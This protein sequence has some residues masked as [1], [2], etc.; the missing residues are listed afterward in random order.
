M[1]YV[2]KQYVK[3]FLNTAKSLKKK[4]IKITEKLPL[5][6]DPIFYQVSQMVIQAFSIQAHAKYGDY[7][8]K[9]YSNDKALAKIGNFTAKKSAQ[10]LC[11]IG[12]PLEKV[13]VTSGLD[14]I[15]GQ[16]SD[17]VG[18]NPKLLAK[19]KLDKFTGQLELFPQK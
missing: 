7:S 16:L 12:Y 3:V 4:G 1:D 9:T 6:V 2:G 8:P 13:W 14:E 15:F 11:K 5:D 17:A 10:F 18:K 19:L